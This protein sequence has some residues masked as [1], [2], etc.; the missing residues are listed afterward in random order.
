MERYWNEE[1]GK[2][3]LASEEQKVGSWQKAVGKSRLAKGNRLITN[4]KGYGG[5]F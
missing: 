1:V 3:Q 5:E 4:T 2:G